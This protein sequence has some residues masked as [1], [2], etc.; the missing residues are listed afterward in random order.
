MDIKW[1]L[2]SFPLGIYVLVFAR[3]Y[4]RL[5][6]FHAKAFLFW[7][8]EKRLVPAGG[9]LSRILSSFHFWSWHFPYRSSICC[10]W[11]F[12]MCNFL[13]VFFFAFSVTFISDQKV[14]RI[15]SYVILLSL[16]SIFCSLPAKKRSTLKDIFAHIP[17]TSPISRC[18][19]GGSCWWYFTF[20]DFVVVASSILYTL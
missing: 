13:F 16:L 19:I 4:M 7:S 10:F 17:D 6:I 2:I 14:L 12:S 1:T 20:Y 15:T 5:N 3:Y 18:L 9:D 11:Q 8:Q